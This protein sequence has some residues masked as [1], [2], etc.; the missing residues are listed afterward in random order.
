[1]SA[2][3]M[4][5]RHGQTMVIEELTQ[6]LDTSGYPSRSDWAPKGTAIFWRQT[7]S[8]AESIRAGHEDVDE[9]AVFYTDADTDVTARDRLNVNTVYYDVEAVIQPGDFPSMTATGHKRVECIR[10][11]DEPK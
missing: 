9:F 5:R 10:K 1:M 4:I 11:N 8:G 2:E 6:V 3:Q 7:R